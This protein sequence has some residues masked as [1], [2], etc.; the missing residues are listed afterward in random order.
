M[1]D[2]LSC[3]RI[4]HD[5]MVV[6]VSFTALTVVSMTSLLLFVVAQLRRRFSYRVHSINFD[7]VYSQ[8][9]SEYKDKGTPKTPLIMPCVC[10]YSWITTTYLLYPTS[11]TVQ[12]RSSSCA[13][14][15]SFAIS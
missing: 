1:K 9:V 3:R 6:D 4:V 12:H 10:M 5:T 2:L 8:L 11:S 7:Y 15:I 14:V 13:R